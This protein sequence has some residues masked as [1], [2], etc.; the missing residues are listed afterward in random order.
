VIS[1]FPTQSYSSLHAIEINKE[2]RSLI[3]FCLHL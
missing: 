2:Q 1:T 3:D